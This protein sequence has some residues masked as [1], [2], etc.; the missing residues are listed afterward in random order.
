LKADIDYGFS[1]AKT[2]YGI[3]GVKCWVYRGDRLA[4]GDAPG[5]VTP[6]GAEDDR[7]PRRNARRGQIRHH[8]DGHGHPVRRQGVRYDVDDGHL[9]RQVA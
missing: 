4:N 6:P 7:R 2:T 3:I 8:L 5:I 1:E 9:Q